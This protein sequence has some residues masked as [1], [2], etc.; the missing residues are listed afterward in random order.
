MF[1]RSCRYNTGPIW[2]TKIGFEHIFEIGIFKGK[3]FALVLKASRILAMSIFLFSFDSFCFSIFE[4]IL[5]VLWRALFHWSADQEE[6]VCVFHSILWIV[7]QDL[8]CYVFLIR[9]LH[10]WFLRRD[11][12]Q[13]TFS[14]TSVIFTALQLNFVYVMSF[15]FL[16]QLCDLA[17]SKKWLLNLW[18]FKFY[19]HLLVNSV[20]LS[21][22]KLICPHSRLLV[23]SFWFRISILKT[24]FSGFFLLDRMCHKIDSPNIT[25]KV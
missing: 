6:Y 1:F 18:N 9:R 13:L 25:Q 2:Q 20:H 15:L 17:H 16:G 19:E 12:L 23:L 10:R 14:M 22:A 11:F 5:F 24:L 3:K 4:M 8:N 21:S 7:F